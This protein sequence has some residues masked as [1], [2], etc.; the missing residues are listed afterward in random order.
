MTRPIAQTTDRP[1]CKSLARTKKLYPSRWKFTEPEK[2]N[3]EPLINNMKSILILALVTACGAAVFANEENNSS[4]KNVKVSTTN[5]GSGKAIVTIEVN[6]K[7]EVRMIELNNPTS[8][9]SSLVTADADKE[10]PTTWLG[11]ACD[12]LSEELAAQLPISRG[13]GV[14]VRHVAENSPAA[15][16]GVQKHD[17]VLKL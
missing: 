5:D 7:K 15:K 11:V 17:I 9:V 3:S 1:T 4:E 10:T 2:H 12:E 8:S 13:T 16:I 14:I 6:G